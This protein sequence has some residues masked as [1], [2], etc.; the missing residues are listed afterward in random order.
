MKRCLIVSLMLLCMTGL[1]SAEDPG[2][3]RL[4][5]EVSVRGYSS[6]VLTESETAGLQFVYYTSSLPL[7]FH[8]GGSIPLNSDWKQDSIISVDLEYIPISVSDHPF[9]RFFSLPSQYAPS[10]RL[11]VL[12]DI[13]GIGSPDFFAEIHPLR[14]NI[15]GGYTSIL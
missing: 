15:G 9:S 3:G 8:L 6:E 10:I 14:F 5:Y 7:A 12:A 11:G 13:K 4:G 1:L 2:H